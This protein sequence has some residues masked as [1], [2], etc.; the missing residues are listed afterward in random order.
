MHVE[1]ATICTISPIRGR[2][3]L[4]V[5]PRS[6]CRMSEQGPH[7]PANTH[8]HTHTLCVRSDLPASR[9][10]LLWSLRWWSGDQCGKK[11]A[12]VNF[13]LLE[14]PERVTSHPVGL[15]PFV[16]AGWL[17][18][19]GGSQDYQE[20]WHFAHEHWLLCHFIALFCMNYSNLL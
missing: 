14:S 19:A 13:C 3:R 6:K 4:V 15:W 5:R 20:S 9:F 10:C 8:S 2:P 18:S 16:C 11:M 7:F 17:V 1:L 12:R